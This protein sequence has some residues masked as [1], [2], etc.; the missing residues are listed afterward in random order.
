M[1]FDKKI[2][3]ILNEASQLTLRKFVNRYKKLDKKAKEIK[4]LSSHSNLKYTEI[5]TSDTK[6]DKV[7]KKLE[8]LGLVDRTKEYA[9]QYSIKMPRYETPDG[10]LYVELEKGNNGK[11]WLSIYEKKPFSASKG[12][13]YYD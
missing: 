13:V 9:H 11:I 5:K 4:P 2:K 12:F 1:K 6:I 10:N 8:S 7:F 3:S